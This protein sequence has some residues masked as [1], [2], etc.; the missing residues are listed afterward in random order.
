MTQN[1][2][3]ETRMLNVTR[4]EA[5]GPD[6]VRIWLQNG[7]AKEYEFIQGEWKPVP[8]AVE[9]TPTLEQDKTRESG[10]YWVKSSGEWGIAQW[11]PD[12]KRWWC[13]MD[14]DRYM[15]AAFEEIGDKIELP[16][17]YR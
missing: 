4:M 9:P 2:T 13:I 1:Q 3:E 15:D 14:E 8:E 17:K 10:Y 16:I 7:K 11:F 5:A 6:K 12:Q